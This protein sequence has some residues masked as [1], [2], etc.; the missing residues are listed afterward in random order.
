MNYA[1]FLKFPK[2]ENKYRKITK[3]LITDIVKARSEE[4]ANLILNSNVNINTFKKRIEK[5]Y[6]VV[7]DE[8]I[9]NNF[10]KNLRFNFLFFIF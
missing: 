10:E 4:I 1:K 3:K 9:S 2:I 6:I 5:I 8:L 7:E